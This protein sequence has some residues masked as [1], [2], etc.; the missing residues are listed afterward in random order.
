VPIITKRSDKTHIE[1]KF[2]TF[3]GI[4][5]PTNVSANCARRLFECEGAFT[6]AG[7]ANEG[8]MDRLVRL[9]VGLIMLFTGWWLLTIGT[10]TFGYVA[11][12]VSGILF[13]TAI[14]GVCP[15]YMVFGVNTCPATPASEE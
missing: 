8:N 4:L 2:V 7:M 13:L 12:A 10:T 15:M 9:A 6:M 5:H 3:C 14:V 11:L 1:Q